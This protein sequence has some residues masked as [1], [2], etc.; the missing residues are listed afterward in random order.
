[1]KGGG[2]TLQINEIQSKIVLD[3]FLLDTKI[4][5]SS[6]TDAVSP[7]AAGRDLAHAPEYTLN[8]G[9]SYRDNQGWFGRFDFTLVDEFYFDISNNEKADNYQIA[10]LRIGKEWQYW[11]VEAWGRNIF[12]EDY[13]TRGFFFGNEPP[14][15]AETRYTKFGDP[16]TIGLTVR[17]SY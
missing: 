3:Q 13:E 2:I 14:A 17:Y 1:M 4:K 15:F 7:G 16:R 9:A 11:T 5:S 12:D 8:V 6:A 10:N